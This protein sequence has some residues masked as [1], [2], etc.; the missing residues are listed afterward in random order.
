MTGCEPI[1]DRTAKEV[2]DLFRAE[3][4]ALFRRARVLTRGDRDAAEDLVQ[5]V[6]AAAAIENWDTVGALGDEDR[7]RWLFTVLMHKA[8]DRWR[9]EKRMLLDPFVLDSELTSQTMDGDPATLTLGSITIEQIWKEMKIMPPAQYRVAYLGWAC[10]WTTRE[11]SGALGIA[12]STV[13]VHRRNAVQALR[14]LVVPLLDYDADEPT[15]TS[16]DED[17]GRGGRDE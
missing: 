9:T 7:R 17:G 13:R 3:A 1:T 2:A 10:G 11:I 14:S 16:V 8:V 12:E 5:E 4:P 15:T 6:F